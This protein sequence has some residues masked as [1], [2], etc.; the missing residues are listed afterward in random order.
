[1]DDKLKLAMAAARAGQKKEAQFL[2][3]QVLQN[4]PQNVNAWFLLS[5]LVD[6]GQKQISY[7]EKVVALDPGHQKA[8]ERLVEL[9]GMVSTP[10]AAE[11]AVAQPPAVEP[12]TVMTAAPELAVEPS[13]VDSIQIGRAH[14]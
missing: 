4:D 12:E 11:P 3:T 9:T 1:M 14:V 10:A 13:G 5:H 7:L 6:S 2:L 8:A